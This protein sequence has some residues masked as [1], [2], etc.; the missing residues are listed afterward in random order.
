MKNR[1]EFN[2][3]EQLDDDDKYKIK[4][5]IK[6]L[7]QQAKYTKLKEEIQSRR[8][9]IERGEVLTHDDIWTNLDV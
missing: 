5:F 3:L 8:E 9:E 6:L 2:M 7:I 4:Y 1:H